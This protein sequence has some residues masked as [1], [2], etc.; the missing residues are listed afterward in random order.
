[1]VHRL[2]MNCMNPTECR[3]AQWWRDWHCYLT[4]RRERLGSTP[5]PG[6]PVF[7]EFA[8]FPLVHVR[9]F[10]LLPPTVQTHASGVRL[11]GDSHR[12]ECEWFS[13]CQPG[14]E[15]GCNLD[16]LPA[17]PPPPQARV[18]FSSNGWMNECL[19]LLGGC[20]AVRSRYVCRTLNTFQ[21]ADF[22]ICAVTGKPAKPTL[23]SV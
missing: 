10:R 11:T 1:M 9:F 19:G 17:P 21:R 5:D 20:R 23:R 4:P 3:A 2:N 18:V 6:L 22:L 8:C 15:P 12:C 14:D 13:L 16:K 7:A